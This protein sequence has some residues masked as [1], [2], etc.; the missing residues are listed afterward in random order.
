MPLDEATAARLSATRTIDLTTRGRRSGRP[1]RIEIW[2]FR[3]EGRFIITGLPGPRHW[4]A[5]L[6]ADPSIIVHAHGEDHHGVARLIEDA[7][8]R[9]RFF[10]QDDPEVRWY[11]D[12]ATLSDLVTRAPMIEVVLD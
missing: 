5:N 4:M 9:Q 7:G 1:S 12:H 3:F 10:I 8:Y 6:A 11:H 2:W